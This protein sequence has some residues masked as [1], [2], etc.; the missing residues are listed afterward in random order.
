MK[1]IFEKWV[2]TPGRKGSLNLLLVGASILIREKTSGST[3]YAAN[4]LLTTGYF[5]LLG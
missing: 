2:N 1:S 3:F 4:Q 5:V